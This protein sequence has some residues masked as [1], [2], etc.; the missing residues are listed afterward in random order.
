MALSYIAQALVV[1]IVGL[2]M[3]FRYSRHC[4]CSGCILL[5]VLRLIVCI[6]KRETRPKNLDIWKK[7]LLPKKYLV[8]A[9][10]PRRDVLIIVPHHGPHSGLAK[11][12][13]ASD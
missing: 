4:M 7:M 12:N 1:T 5:R 2:N 11:T 3:G 8:S 6:L 13:K 10:Q 9:R